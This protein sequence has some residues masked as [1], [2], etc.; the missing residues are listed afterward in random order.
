[1]ISLVILEALHLSKQEREIKASKVEEKKRKTQSIWDSLRAHC[2]I[3]I[4]QGICTGPLRE[5]GI[6]PPNHLNMQ[7]GSWEGMTH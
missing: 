4:L 7:W 2:Q 3:I 6:R 5:R 1:M